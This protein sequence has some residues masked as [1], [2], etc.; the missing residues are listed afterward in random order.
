MEF[1]KNQWLE[2]LEP[3]SNEVLNE[4]ILLCRDHSE[5]PPSLPQMIGF[6]RD[7]KKRRAFYV[8]QK[9]YQPASEAV[10]EQYI[11]Q[12]KAYLI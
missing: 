10:V 3:F 8:A 4:A 7:I 2:G 1:A 6:C 11:R 12:C 5:M 9:T